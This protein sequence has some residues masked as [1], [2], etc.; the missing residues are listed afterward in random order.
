MHVLSL[1][2]GDELGARAMRSLF[3]FMRHLFRG[4]KPAFFKL[5]LWIFKLKFV[6]VQQTPAYLYNCSFTAL[7]PGMPLIPKKTPEASN[8]PFKSKQIIGI[9]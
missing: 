8:N 6:L 1:V 9:K 7:A 3:N 4:H 5:S 2:P